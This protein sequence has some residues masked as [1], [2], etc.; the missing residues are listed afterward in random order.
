MEKNENS[1]IVKGD[2]KTDAEQT[3]GTR[4][5]VTRSSAAKIVGIWMQNR[6]SEPAGVTRRRTKVR[7]E[8]K[9]VDNQKHKTKGT[10][11]KVFLRYLQK[12]C[13]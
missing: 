7:R 10:P 11:I 9:N 6:Q 2:E 8:V 4:N 13:F 3:N 12:L 1:P 5:A